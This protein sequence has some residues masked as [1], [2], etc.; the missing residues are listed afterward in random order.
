MRLTSSVKKPRN[1]RIEMKK[2]KIVMFLRHNNFFFHFKESA[3]LENLSKSV[4][5]IL[6]QFL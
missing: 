2:E 5:S 1:Y 6:Y 3:I 4:S